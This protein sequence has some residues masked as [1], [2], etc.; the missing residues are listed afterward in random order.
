MK[1]VMDILTLLS[2]LGWRLLQWRES[3]RL[4]NLFED[5]S[6]NFLEHTIES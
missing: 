6:S 3:H 1:L 4:P 5:C 2:N